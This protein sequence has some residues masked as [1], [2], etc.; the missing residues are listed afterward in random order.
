MVILRQSSS[1]NIDVIGEELFPVPVE[2]TDYI[3][4]LILLPKLAICKCAN[5]Y[6][7]ACLYDILT[8]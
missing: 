6:R 3:S 4:Q 5:Q 8:S 7:Y 2:G 1:H